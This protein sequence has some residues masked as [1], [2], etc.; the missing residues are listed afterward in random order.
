M[1]KWR[2]VKL[3]PEHDIQA[4]I[5]APG[6]DLRYTIQVKD[7]GNP[8]SR[9]FSVEVLVT[10]IWAGNIRTERKGRVSW[11]GLYK[12]EGYVSSCPQ[13]TRSDDLLVMTIVSVCF[14]LGEKEGNL[15]VIGI[16]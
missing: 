14:C 15:E 12:F 3:P 10:D 8:K 6:Q 4:D 9:P 16:E 1:P 11:Y 2:V 7:A 13:L 5:F